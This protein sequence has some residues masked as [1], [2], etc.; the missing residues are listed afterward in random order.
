MVFANES[1]WNHKSLEAI[2]IYNNRHVS[3]IPSRLYLRLPHVIEIQVAKCSITRIMS[4]NFVNLIEVHVLILSDNII[5]DIAE[6][7]FND[8]INL[9]EILMK[10]NRLTFLPGELFAK[11]RFLRHINFSN[12]AIKSLSEKLLTTPKKLE[13]IY[14]QI[15]ALE[16][17][18]N[19]LFKENFELRF[20]D[21]GFNEIK[22]VTSNNLSPILGK[23]RHAE[24][25]NFKNNIC[26]DDCYIKYL[27][28]QKVNSK[29]CSFYQQFELL[30]KKNC[31][32]ILLP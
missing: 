29:N 21:F 19:D 8:L 6:N 28:G 30:F 14:F 26:I 15:N 22:Y 11:L 31:S 10:N 27:N 3:F 24:T 25:A 18:P 9:E 13:Q 23:I 32:Q 12:N 17:L 2:N 16:F 7:A 1:M 5:K 20:I 4:D